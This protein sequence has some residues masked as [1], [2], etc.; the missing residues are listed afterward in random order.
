M[1]NKDLLDCIVEK[2]NTIY[3]KHLVCEEQRADLY[4]YIDGLEQQIESI[5]D[6]M[7]YFVNDC[8]NVKLIDADIANLVYINNC[9]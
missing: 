2:I 7:I 5:D 3:S 1:K 6:E 4:V 8:H 9:I